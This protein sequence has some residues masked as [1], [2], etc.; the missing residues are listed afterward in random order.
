MLPEPG[1]TG[2]ALLKV[3]VLPD[4]VGAWVT[5]LGAIARELGITARYEAFAGHGII[6]ARLTG[7]EDTLASAIE[8]LRAAAGPVP[9]QGSLV[10]W[11]A[12]AALTRR[13]DVWGPSPALEVMRRVKGAFDPRAAF[14]PGRF[15]G[16]I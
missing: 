6:F 1:R 2:S 11:D 4:R 13:V 16:R 9:Q 7:G 10:V 8:P 14:N 12:P 5:S 3:S 15:I